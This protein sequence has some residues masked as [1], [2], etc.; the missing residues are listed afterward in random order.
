MKRRQI[1]AAQVRPSPLDWF[2]D[3]R[4][5]LNGVFSDKPKYT[6]TTA[7]FTLAEQFITLLKNGMK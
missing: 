2:S 1:V 4:L 7:R 5:C 6:I 3:P